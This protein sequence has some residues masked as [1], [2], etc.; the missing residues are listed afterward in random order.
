MREVLAVRAVDA[1]AQAARLCVAEV[2]AAADLEVLLLARRPGLDVDRLDLEVREVARA[3]LERAHRD[4]HA[5][6]QVDRVLPELVVPHH[7]VLGLADDDH[8]LLLELVDAV[9]AAL[10]DAVRALFLAEAGRIAR[11]R[12]RQLGLGQNLVDELADHR[13]LARADEVEVLALDLVHHR[14]HL[15]E[16]HDAGDDVAADH[17]RR[18]HIREA[19]VDHE[20]ARVGDDGRVQ[21][22]D[23]AHQ[24]VEAVAGDAARGVE[25]DAVEALHDLGV[26]RHR[27]V[28]RDRLAVTL[29]LDVLAV[30]AADRHAR[31][32]DVRDRHHDLEDALVELLLLRLRREQLVGLRLDLRLDLLGLVA[33]ALAHQRADLLREL[34][35]RGAQAVRLLLRLPLLH[36]ELDHLVDERELAVLKLLFDVFADRIRIFSQKF[37]VDHCFSSFRLYFSISKC[38]SILI[39]FRSHSAGGRGRTSTP[40][41]RPSARKREFHSRTAQSPPSSRSSQTEAG[42]E[43][44]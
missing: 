36:V 18:D 9:H 26:V 42:S 41:G 3:A 14:V 37:N 16:A 23:V 33:L 21:A 6:E 1:D 38:L 10:L 39:R 28:R 20:V 24:V 32:D 2:R 27:E 7:R 35:A 8:L 30:V 31:V 4:V 15:G 34:V 29:D 22:R 12:Q 19:A 13:V 25:V 44:N 40:A 17:V 43:S 11:E 5:A